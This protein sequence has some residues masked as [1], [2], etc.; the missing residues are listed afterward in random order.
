MIAAHIQVLLKNGYIYKEPSEED[1]RSFYVLP[2]EKAKE[3]EK[4]YGET[5]KSTGRTRC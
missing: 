4:M 2:T 1:G 3:L 5:P